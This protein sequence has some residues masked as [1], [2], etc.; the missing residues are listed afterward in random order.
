M[1][2]CAGIEWVVRYLPLALQDWLVYKSFNLA[3][4]EPVLAENAAALRQAQQASSS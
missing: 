3:A 4:L 2:P 1:G